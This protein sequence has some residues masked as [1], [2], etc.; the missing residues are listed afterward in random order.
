M[1]S[2]SGIIGLYWEENDC[3]ASIDFD[4]SGYYCYIADSADEDR[5]RAAGILPYRLAE[6]IAMTANL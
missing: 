6:V 3:Y 4:G 5:V 2:G 1:M